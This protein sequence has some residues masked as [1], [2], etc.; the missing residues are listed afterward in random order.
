MHVTLG[1]PTPLVAPS[2]L[3]PA[4][5]IRANHPTPEEPQEEQ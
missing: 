4:E 1:P 2:A 5:I 3:E